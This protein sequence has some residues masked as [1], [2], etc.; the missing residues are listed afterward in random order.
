MNGMGGGA[1]APLDALAVAPRAPSC[2]GGTS[3]SAGGGWR[4]FETVNATASGIELR[5]ST[6]DAVVDR[7]LRGFVAACEA[8]SPG[9]IRCFLLAGGYAEGTATPLS[10]VDAGPIFRSDT[11]PVPDEPRRASALFR[12]CSQPC[13]VHLDA[14]YGGEDG[15]YEYH[16]TGDI[17]LARSAVERRVY[18]KLAQRVLYGEDIRPRIP[19]PSIQWWARACFFSPPHHYVAPHFMALTRDLAPGDGAA[20]RPLVYPLDYPDPEDPFRG[21]ART[22]LTGRDGTVHP[23]TRGI[24]RT[25]LSGAMA[26]LAWK[27]RRYDTHKGQLAAAYCEH[28]GG[29]WSDFVEAVDRTCRVELGYLVPEHRAARERLRA[30]CREMPG[31]ENHV[32]ERHRAFVLEQIDQA[33]RGAAGEPWLPAELAGWLLE[34]SPDDVRALGASGRRPSAWLDGRRRFALRPCL[35]RWAAA[36]LGRVLHPDDSATAA[37]LDALAAADTADTEVVRRA[38]RAPRTALAARDGDRR[39]ARGTV[40]SRR[41]L[42]PTEDPP[43]EQ[44]HTSVPLTC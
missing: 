34:T 2:P 32:L 36:M 11:P 31:F 41:A 44:R 4:R 33:A 17:W 5:F 40:L 37:A 24:V 25:V 6:G 1:I 22:P 43:G 15:C 29:P 8:A 39:H 27:A 14:G 13:G 9:R 19:L 38:V 21:Y 20:A 12:A 10:D 16:D 28:V 30:L 23:T 26:L 18:V 35:E 3:E 7:V 42:A